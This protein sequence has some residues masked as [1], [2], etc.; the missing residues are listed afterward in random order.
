MLLS[1]LFEFSRKDA[2]LR[3]KR[4]KYGTTQSYPQ[5]SDVYPPI[6]QAYTPPPRAPPP[7]QQVVL[8][9]PFTL[10]AIG[11]TFSGKSC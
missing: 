9:H 2:M 8:Q 5:S 4:N 10:M 3:H 6:S 1:K 11:P 7:P